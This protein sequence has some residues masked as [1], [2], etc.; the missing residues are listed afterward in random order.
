M[1][2]KIAALFGSGENV[3]K[4]IEAI[5]GI[6]D[7]LWTSEDEKLDRATIM[8]RLR[9]QPALAQV[10][11]NKI[12]AASKSLFVSGWRPSLG[13]VC[14]VS[15]FTYFV[16]QYAVGAVVWVIAVDAAGWGVNGGLPPYPVS[17]DAVL[18]LV[19][20]MLGL[21]GVRTLE[22]FGGVARSAK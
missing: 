5:G 14:S 13:W 22:K 11:L 2:G 12:E 10:G 9:Q 6:I 21:V 4:P 17:P 16:P 8:E 1:L 20:A 3:A 19:M 18:E 15:L 7:E